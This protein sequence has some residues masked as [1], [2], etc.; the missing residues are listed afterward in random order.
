MRDKQYSMVL[1]FIFL[2][3]NCNAQLSTYEKPV[4]FDLSTVILDQLRKSIQTVEM[5]LLD[6]T[7]IEA[8]DKEDEEYD[9]PPRFGYS[10]KVNYNLTNSG[11]W[12]SLPNGDKIWQLN[13]ICPGALSVNF[14]YDKFWIPEGGK[15]FVYSKDRKHSIGAFT[16]RNNKGTMDN[17]RGFATGLVYGSDIILEYYQPKNVLSD[18][19]ISIEYVV[20]GYRYINL[21]EKGY[22]NAGSCMVNVNCEEGQNW[23]NEKKAV[24]MIVVNNNRICSGSLINTTDLSQSPLFLTADHCISSFDRDAIENPNLDEFSFYWNY[25]APGCL[26]NNIEPTFYST[27]G[28]TLLANNSESDFALL[29]LTEDPK[30]L[31]N[32]TPFY[33]GWDCS[34]QSGEA[35]VCIHHPKGDVKK[36]STVLSQPT[37]PYLFCWSVGWAYTINGHSMTQPGSSGSA[38]INAE[39][40]IIGQLYGG[41]CGNCSNANGKSTYG[42]FHVSWTGNYNDTIQRRLNCWLDSLNTGAQ[43]MEGLLVIPTTSTL[44]TDQQFYGNILITD[45]GQ[46]SIQSN[47]E[48]MGNSRIFVEA[49]GKLIINGGTLSNTDIILKPGATLQII[50]GG[51]IETRNGFVAPVGA[52]VNIDYGQIL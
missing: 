47:V 9:M 46:L 37:S 16:S 2:F 50:N 48:M 6:M 29:R 28:A 27:S 33:L 17:I 22:G 5:P 34:G 8:E 39:H 42:Q 20:H 26:N 24:A 31:S 14:G 15:F 36:I 35:G 25:E 32:Y 23:Q 4:S 45:I 11:T 44:N 49:G 18:A 3:L 21:G 10:Y 1:F 40:M 13:I 30:D 7:K 51:I 43:T 52:Y 19:V 41:T 12:T 38:L